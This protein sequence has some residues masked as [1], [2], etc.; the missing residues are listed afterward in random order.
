[1]NREWMIAVDNWLAKLNYE[2]T[3]EMPIVLPKPPRLCDFDPSFDE[4]LDPRVFR[5]RW[6]E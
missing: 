3:N 6:T 1:M 4:P 2:L 5:S